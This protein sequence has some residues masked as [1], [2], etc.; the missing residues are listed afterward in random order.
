MR[1]SYSAYDTFNRCPL[2]YKFSYI[3]QIERPEKPELFF[4]S[5][6]HKTVQ[7]ALKKDPILPK[8][9]EL[10]DFLKI[11]WQPEIF[12]SKNESQQYFEF[13]KEM[14]RK[15]YADWQPGLRNIVATEKYFQVPL[16]SKHIL[17]GLIDRIDKLP[18]GAF[19]IIDYKT[20]K[21]LPTQL[22]IDT[23]KQLAIYNLAVQSLWPEAQDVRLTLYFLKHNLKIT[24][25][26][27]PYEIEQIKT[28]VINIAD[29]I[30]NEKEF[31]PKAN[32]FCDWC[33]FRHLC[34]LQEGKVEN[35]EQNDDINKIIEEYI[36]A[37]QKIKDLEPQIHQHFDLEKIEE[38]SNKEI[39]ITR[40]KDKKIII[41]N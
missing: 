12:S 14:I 39:T 29:K 13:G 5:L 27:Q 22:E 17:S 11:K 6:I 3:E 30:E 2:Q 10:M 37:Q 38:F 31:A 33:D 4:G 35:R 40:D 25:K 16:S 41:K 36:E 18:Y 8:E 1:I 21:A 20:N 24:T 7:F 28:E 23:D 9:Q 19:E 34:P 15:F 26:R 32:K